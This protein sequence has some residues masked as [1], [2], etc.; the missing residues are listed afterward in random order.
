MRNLSSCSLQHL[1]VLLASAA[2]LLLSGCGGGA[3][4]TSTTDSDATKG[5]VVDMAAPGLSNVTDAAAN[6]AMMNSEA[7]YEGGDYESGG[8][9]GGEYDG[10]M[11]GSESGMAGMGMAMEGPP[12]GYEGSAGMQGGGMSGYDSQ[13]GYDPG[14][15]GGQ[16]GIGGPSGMGGRPATPQ[17]DFGSW[18]KTE[19]ISAVQSKDR[20]IIAAID[21]QAESRVG[22]PEFAKLM[23]DVLSESTGGGSAASGGSGMPGFPT[24]LEPGGANRGAG[25][26][27]PPG[28]ASLDN[29]DRLFR[30]RRNNSIDSIEAMLGESILTYAPQA[31]QAIRGSV[32]RTQTGGGEGSSSMSAMQLTA[33]KSTATT[34]QGQPG[35]SSMTPPGMGPPGAPN[36]GG[37]NQPGMGAANQYMNEG[38]DYEGSDGYSGQAYQS[39]NSGRQ[40]LAGL[41]QEELVQAITSALVKNNSQDAWKTLVGMVDGSA[42]TGLTNDETIAMVLRDTFTS[43]TINPEMA[44][45][46]LSLATDKILGSPLETPASLQLLAELSTKPLDHFLGLKSASALPTMNQTRGQGNGFGLS[47]NAGGSNIPGRPAAANTGGFG[48]SEMGMGMG[49]GGGESGMGMGPGGGGEMGMGMGPGGGGEM[50]MGMGSGENYN[51]GSDYGSGNAYGSGFGGSPGL[52]T[53][54]A[55]TLNV[56][57]DGMMPIAS[58]LWSNSTSQKIIAAIDSGGPGMMALASTIPSNTIRRTLFEK[59]QSSY[60]QGA[61]GAFGGLSF[62]TLEPGMLPILKGLPRLRPARSNAAPDPTRAPKETWVNTT[63]QV[64]LALRE[65]LRKAASNPDLANPGAPKIRLHRGAIPE[66]SIVINLPNELAKELGD[67]APANTKIYYTRTSVTPQTPGQ[68]E[69]LATH[70]EKN[71]KGFRRVDLAN[72]MLWFDGVTRNTDGTRQSLDVII[73]Q[74]GGAAQGNAGYGG[75]GGGYEGEGGGAGGYNPGGP[76]GGFGGP[77]GGQTAA[78]GSFTIETIVVV[79]RDPQDPIADP[80][81]TSASLE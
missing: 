77:P 6:G 74:S 20:N 31:A 32:Q 45:Q 73:Q 18:T 12:G 30:H 43:Q 1:S 61:D 28:G 72:K 49:P 2:S 51:E 41:T 19:F 76:Q 68:Q 69:A 55:T 78:G 4:E 46:I 62:A 17:I 60:T 22:D 39:Q 3:E 5:A 63:K 33:P 34:N 79:T 26:L 9:D 40:N 27:V 52:G 50:G 36:G 25:G 59:F 10:G 57:T 54:L 53:A 29:L 24:G 23:S 21:V 47:A 58:V 16:P 65:R 66:Q 81:V 56:P 37:R 11:S 70:Y 8:H 7:G 75:G 44:E 64:V 42:P 71:A 14:Q 35:S 38:S 80:T 67:S 15:Y 13:E 48:A